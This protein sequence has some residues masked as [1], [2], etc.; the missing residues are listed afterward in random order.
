MRGL[1]KAAFEGACEVSFTSPNQRAQVRDAYL[2]A[3]VGLDIVSD[4]TDLPTEKP[5]S[6]CILAGTG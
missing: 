4:A 5:V 1:P 3:H 6:D 2:R